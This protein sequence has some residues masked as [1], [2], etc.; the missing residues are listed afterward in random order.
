M[1]ENAS[2]NIAEELQSMPREQR[3]SMLFV[4]MVMQTAEMALMFLS[5]APHPQTGEPVYNIDAAR[6]FI[7]QLEALEEKTKGNLDP[8]EA[9]MLKQSLMQTRMA[10]VQAV[11]NPPQDASKTPEPAPGPAASAAP[12]GDAEATKPAEEEPHKR[13][14]K[15]F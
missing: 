2:P 9:L 5:K 8:Q 11:E 3:L 15:K 13:F 4:Q 1:K 10:F 6:L 7:D 12:G 14:S